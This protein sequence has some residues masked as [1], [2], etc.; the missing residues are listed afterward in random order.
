VIGCIADAFGAYLWFLLVWGPGHACKEVCLQQVC[1]QVGAGV[2]LRTDWWYTQGCQYHTHEYWLP[3]QLAW[4]GLI[5]YWSFRA[6]P[7][8][9]SESACCAGVAGCSTTE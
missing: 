3:G 5:C 2:C 9:M 8:S 7:W 1:L 4:L 6:G